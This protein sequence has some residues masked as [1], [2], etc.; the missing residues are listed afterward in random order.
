[1]KNLKSYYDGERIVLFHKSPL[2][3]MIASLHSMLKQEKSGSESLW[4]SEGKYKKLN[5]SL[6]YNIESYGKAYSNW[7]LIMDLATYISCRYFDRTGETEITFQQAMQEYRNI[8][9]KTYLYFFLG[10]PALGL[11]KE[12][13]DEWINAPDSIKEE[14]LEPIEQYIK[15][16][17]FFI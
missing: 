10:M 7:L 14:S 15:K 4:L 17:E 2:V 6:K 5:P 1:M 9:D 8:D 3:E 16:K 12:S 11:D 13:L